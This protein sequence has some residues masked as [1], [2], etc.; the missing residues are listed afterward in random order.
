M[1]GLRLNWRVENENPP[2]MSSNSEVGRSIQTPDPQEAPVYKAVLAPSVDVLQQLGDLTLVI[3]L[4]TDVNKS[5]EVNAFFNGY[6]L[7]K[8]RM[9]WT[10]AESHCK[11]NGGHLASIHSKWDQTLAEMAA[12]G[13]QVWIGGRQSN[14]R[15]QWTDDSAWGFTNWMDGHPKKEGYPGKGFQLVMDYDGEWFDP[16]NTL[17]KYF[18]C[19][20]TT[21]AVAWTLQTENNLARIELGKEQMFLFPF[22]VL[23]KS[24]AKTSLN[25]SSEEGRR[26][27]GFTLNWFLMN[28]NGTQS[29]ERLPAREEDWRQE[30]PTPRYKDPMLQDMMEIAKE[31]R[32]Q[33]MTKEE[34]LTMII[35]QKGMPSDDEECPMEQVKPGRFRNA[36]FS[37]VFHDTDKIKTE[38][39]ITDV[40]FKSGY[41]LFH[42]VEFCPPVVL[43]KLY[44]FIDQLLSNETSRTIIQT[45]VNLFQSGAITDKTSL[46]LAKQFYNVLASTLDLQY[47]NI[48]LATSK[49]AQLHAMK[50]DDWPFF[51]ENTDLVEKCLAES[52]CGSFREIL[53]DLGKSCFSVSSSA[54]NS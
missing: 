52:E 32:L 35:K 28:R 8:K 40:D 43:F 54:F 48:L 20:E 33:N 37:N 11:S 6:Q 5:D 23:F 15:W 9:D 34:I 14:G 13:Y 2:L 47:G 42:A 36:I 21:T 49:N 46:T 44:N 22:H 30:V 53:K 51:A 3:E 1:T 18:L 12:K 45:I 31:L 27:S 39:H 24:P 10:N 25:T 17:G 41:E 16:P 26:T 19:K 4:H 29:S 7:Y 38:G 50:R